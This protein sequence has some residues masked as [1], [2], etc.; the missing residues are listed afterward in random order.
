MV[1]RFRL[2]FVVAR[3]TA[4]A[5]WFAAGLAPHAFA[6]AVDG[7]GDDAE[8][9]REAS[10]A[11]ESEKRAEAMAHVAAGYLAADTDPDRALHH[12][13]RALERDLSNHSLAREV[14]A[15]LL[16]RGDVPEALAVLKDSLKRNPDSAALA[17]RIAGIYA[18]TLRKLEPAE[19]FAR[20]AL[21]A[22][23][24]LIECYQMLYTV[25]RAAG[26][27]GEAATLL[28][29]AAKRG[30]DRPEFWA[31]LGDLC[32]RQ[33]LG[34]GANGERLR[35][36]ALAHYRRAAELA[37]QDPVVLGRAL[38][39]FF[40][41]GHMD[42]AISAANRLLILDPSDTG[43]REKLALALVSK[44]KDDDALTELTRVQADNPASL[45]AY[46]AHGEILLKRGDYENAVGKYEMALALNDEDPRLY[47]EVADLCIKAENYDRAVHWLGEA[48]AKFN[49]LPEFPFYEAQVLGHLKRWREAL[50]A[51]DMAESLAKLYQPSFLDADFYFQH[52]VA[53]ERAGEHGEA[54]LRFQACLERDGN[55]A[56]ALNYLGYMWADRGENLAQA[57]EYIRRALAQEP[58]NPAYLD[59]LGWVCHQQGRYHEALV[60]LERAVQLASEPD[61]TIQEHLGDV[62]EKLGRTKDAI[63]AWE[64]A[65]TLEGA[66]PDIATKLQRAK[67]GLDLSASSVT[68]PA[69]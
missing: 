17:L 19:R 7:S 66:S 8:Q 53:A 54:V 21:A 31:G 23:P 34:G 57:E 4:L 35:T 48:R 64:R 50:N 11:P 29:R 39:F 13:L 18:V 36:E 12:N 68:P 51:L 46:R 28:D 38:N 33:L 32:I 30:N 1:A 69:R 62:L 42:D 58:D 67:G 27:P 40:A 41:G 10:L 22:D 9:V 16:Q 56:A 5:V 52:G 20:Q 49:R 25:Q 45:M 37:R 60:P 47:L 14:S 63:K 6:A 3:F 44:G 61:A 24:D 15:A 55:Y 65:A 2:R 26:Q 43:V 59:S